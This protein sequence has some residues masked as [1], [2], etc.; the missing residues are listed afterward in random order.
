MS[1]FW[2]VRENMLFCV[3]CALFTLGALKV[4]SVLMVVETSYA[5]EQRLVDRSPATSNLK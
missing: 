4:T 3:L 2:K 5:K 1:R